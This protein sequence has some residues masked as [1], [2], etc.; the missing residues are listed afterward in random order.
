[1]SYK[2]VANRRAWWPVTVPVTAEDG[3]VGEHAFELRFIL[4]KVD[5]QEELEEI[6]KAKMVE[7]VKAKEAG[8]D[9]TSS[10]VQRDM[11]KM[12]ADDWRGVL[13]ENE[14][15]LVWNDENVRLLMNEPRLFDRAMVAYRLCL[16]GGQE[17]RQ[18]N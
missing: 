16:A 3:T 9:V 1:M 6:V 10:M 17:I 2:I 11:L 8:D 13:A 7:A 14:E 18:G 15:P 4:H 12:F 5:R